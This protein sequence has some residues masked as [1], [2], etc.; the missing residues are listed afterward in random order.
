MENYLLNNKVDPKALKI[1]LSVISASLDMIEGELEA[2]KA[3]CAEIVT[4][5][6][7]LRMAQDAHF[8]MYKLLHQTQVKP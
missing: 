2:P 1:S 6:K 5:R 7:V 4:L 3:A 8:E